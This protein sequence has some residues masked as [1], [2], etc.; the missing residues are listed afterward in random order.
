MPGR[1]VEVSWSDG[2]VHYEIDVKDNRGRRFAP[3]EEDVELRKVLSISTK[4]A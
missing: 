1:I 3:R 2:R 4:I